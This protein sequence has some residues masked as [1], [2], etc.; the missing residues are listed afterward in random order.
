MITEYDMSLL[1]KLWKNYK[2][3]FTPW[4]AINLADKAKKLE[5]SQHWD[6]S[7]M[8]EELLKLL[9]E[10]QTPNES[11][12]F[13]D[14]RD[15][16]TNFAQCHCRN[17]EVLLEQFGFQLEIKCSKLPNGGQ[18]VFIKNGLVPKGKI[19]CLYP[20]LI[21]KP[22]NPILLASIR[23]AYIFRCTDGSM[24]DGKSKGLSKTMFKSIHGRDRLY[25]FKPMCDIS[26]IHVEYQYHVNPLN[27]GQIVNNQSSQFKANVMYEE[28][29]IHC[30]SF[31]EVLSLLPNINYDSLHRDLRIVPLI[32]TRDI[33]P[34]EELYSTYFSII[35]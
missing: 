22:Y 23:N 19:V 7:L 4:L 28:L 16:R 2:Y 12:I 35:K 13:R 20:G 6:Q 3:R 33:Q 9:S 25:G 34:G 29:D 18:G 1:K 15:R 8:K 30:D 27:I 17:Q 26:W 31:V 32:A 11:M 10:F 21:Y 14:S 24:I 5:P